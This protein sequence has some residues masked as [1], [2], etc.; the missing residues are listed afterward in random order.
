MTQEELETEIREKIFEL[1]T[2]NPV[3]MGPDHDPM[4]GFTGPVRTEL[5]EYITKLIE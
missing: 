3:H 4:A 1:L 5:I 2:R